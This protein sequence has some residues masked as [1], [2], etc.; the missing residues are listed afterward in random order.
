M[1]TYIQSLLQRSGQAMKTTTYSDFRKNLTAMMNSVNEDHTPV[2]I[3]RGGEAPPAV[4]IS[5]EDF[6]AYAETAYLMSTKANAERLDR[7]IADLRAGGGTER[8][9]DLCD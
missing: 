3:T 4:L 6:N 9:L 5:L 8:D 7:A 1:S 2:L